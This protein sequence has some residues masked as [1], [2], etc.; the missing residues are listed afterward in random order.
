MKSEL[1][2]ML[3]HNDLT[4]ENA[5]EV[6]D[7]CRETPARYWGFKEQP[8][9]LAEMQRIYAHM[10]ACGKRTVL[11]VVAYTEA[12]GLAGAQMA[13]DCGCD[14]LMG[15]CY[16]PTILRFC[17]EHGIAYMPFIGQIEGRPSVLRGSVESMITEATKL[18]ASGAYGIDLLGYRYDGDAEE[19]IR[20]VVAE[21]SHPVC[22]AGSIDSY[23]RL[24]F[25]KTVRPWAFTIGSAFFD[26]RFGDTIADQITRV[27]EY[28]ED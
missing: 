19:L 27:C 24:D 28:M 4:V 8:L 1:I 13:A 15:T 11:E 18:A 26:H 22:V 17:Q 14:I 10:K 16:H 3:T 23:E 9:P 21:T 7:A 25:V 12:E 5:Y 2:V 20:H 6:F